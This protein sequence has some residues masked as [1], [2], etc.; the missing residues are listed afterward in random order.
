MVSTLEIFLYNLVYVGL[1]YGAII[2]QKVGVTRSPR[3][4]EE[5]YIAVLKNLA[6]NKIWLAGILLN[7]LSVPYFAA[8]L[9][10][11]TISFIMICQRLGLIIIFIFSIKYMKE[12]F[13]KTE[14][15]GLIVVFASMLLMFSVFTNSQ[16]TTLYAG[17]LP[18]FFFFIIC[19]VIEVVTFLSYN[20]LKNLK[21]K[22]V[23]LAV[24]AGMSGVAGTLALKVVPLVLHRDLG[25]APGTPYVL[26]MFNLPEFFTIFFSI[27]VPGSPYFFGAIYLWL[28]I[29]NFMAN[30]FLLTMMYQHGRAGVTIPINTSLNFLISI[31]FGFFM[32]AEPI[33]TLSWVGIAFMVSG[34]LLTS[35]IESEAV[36]KKPSPDNAVSPNGNLEPVPSPLERS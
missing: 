18:G 20:K 33:D 1:V 27:F 7:I 16:A 5:R 35:K 26:N 30:F 15:I 25:I 14:V 19:G 11:S 6:K 9:S 8:L 34:I 4:G 32:C 24:G 2:F 12:R 28:W 13:K 36:A 31:L 29:G 23:L 3:F 10:I 21:V 22:E 17:D